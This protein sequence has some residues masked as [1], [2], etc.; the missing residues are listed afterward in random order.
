L[1]D[2]LQF[3]SRHR[4]PQVWKW[5]EGTCLS[6]AEVEKKVKFLAPRIKPG[7]EYNKANYQVRSL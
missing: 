2:E 7:F 4:R 5:R 6:P 1:S 3:S